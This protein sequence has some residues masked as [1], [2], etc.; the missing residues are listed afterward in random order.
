MTDRPAVARLC[1]ACCQR[2]CP[3][4]Q[5]RCDT[6]TPGHQPAHDQRAAR[7]KKPRPK[8]DL[9]QGLPDS[10]AGYTIEDLL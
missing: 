2:F 8:L 10:L 7:I 3:I 1:P 6:C 5:P 9:S 4:T